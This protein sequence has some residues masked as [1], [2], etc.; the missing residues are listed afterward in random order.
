MPNA[1]KTVVAP[2]K[3]TRVLF[4][5]MESG[6]SAHP[7]T[8]DSQGAHNQASFT[9]FGSPTKTFHEGENLMLI[10]EPLAELDRLQ[11]AEAISRI[12]PLWRMNAA[13]PDCVQ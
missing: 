13:A 9:R 11:R 3:A 7:I 2:Q 12:L 10:D 1:V 6:S 4:S 5:C 8:G